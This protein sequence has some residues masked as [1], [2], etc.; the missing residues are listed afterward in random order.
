MPFVRVQR[1]EDTRQSHG[2]MRDAQGR[3]SPGPRCRWLAAL[4]LAACA[5]ASAADGTRLT[6]RIVAIVNDEVI[7]LSE[8]KALVH[9]V[10][11]RLRQEYQG[12]ALDRRLRQLES[13]ALTELI[14]RRLQMQLARKRGHE[15][16]EEEVQRALREFPPQTLNGDPSDPLLRKNVREQITMMKVLEREVRS[17]VTVTEEEIERYYEEHKAHFRLPQEYHISQILIRP[18]P[19]EERADARQRAAEVYEKLSNGQDFAELATSQSD[20]AGAA[21][22]GSLGMVREGELAFELEQAI[23]ELQLGQISRPVETERGF[24]IIRL[25]D[26]TPPRYKALPLVKSEIQNLVYKEKSERLYH[27][28]IGELKD[29]AYIE[30]K[31]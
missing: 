20:G 4:L 31:F 26:R 16:T 7:T 19:G 25:D 29:H 8:V 30:V 13:E 24:H 28:W 10:E 6:D 21:H 11:R 22:G 15:A 27:K 3:T 1:R 9:G 12:A 17:G 18:R 2:H 23:A 14:E 5:P